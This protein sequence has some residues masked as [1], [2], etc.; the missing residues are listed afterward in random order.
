MMLFRR[1]LRY[2]FAF[3]FSKRL[4]NALLPRFTRR[5]IASGLDLDTGPFNRA[6]VRRRELNRANLR[7][8]RG[9]L[10]SSNLA[11]NRAECANQIRLACERQHDDAR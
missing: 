5:T 1:I 4:F 2:I 6:I 3:N 9:I 11:R 7:A 8:N 10:E